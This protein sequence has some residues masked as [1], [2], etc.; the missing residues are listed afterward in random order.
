VFKLVLKHRV[1]RY[2]QSL[3]SRLLYKSFAQKRLRLPIHECRPTV[4]K[5]KLLGVNFDN[6]GPFETVA[7]NKSVIFQL[8]S[9]SLV[10]TSIVEA[11]QI[12]IATSHFNFPTRK[13]SHF[14]VLFIIIL[15][16]MR[17]RFQAQNE[18]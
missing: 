16:K 10:S 15:Q 2:K 13:Y 7:L 12:K 4:A 14:F 18:V 8:R 5:Q 6:R 1:R 11:W 3:F 9:E 17:A